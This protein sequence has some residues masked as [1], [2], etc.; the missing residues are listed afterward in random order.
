MSSFGDGAVSE[1]CNKAYYFLTSASGLIGEVFEEEGRALT[2][3]YD[4]VLRLVGGG[5]WKPSEIS[6]GPNF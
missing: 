1:L 2:R 6:G 5:L 3:V 4:A